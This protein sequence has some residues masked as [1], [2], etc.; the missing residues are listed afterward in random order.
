MYCYVVFLKTVPPVF[1]PPTPSIS[2]SIENTRPIVLS[3]WNSSTEYCSELQSTD[4]AIHCRAVSIPQPQVDI[5][6]N[7]IVTE[8]SFRRGQHEAVV[9]SA[10]IP[11]GEVVTFECQASTETVTSIV[12]VNLTYTCT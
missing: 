8:P 11:Y 7:G 1:T 10:P 6:V 4:I 5:L 9:I 12:A 2:V 3:N